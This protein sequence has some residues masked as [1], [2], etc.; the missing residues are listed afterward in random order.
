M[1]PSLIE[2]SSA[3]PPAASTALR[4]SVYSTSST[5]SVARKATRLPLIEVVIVVPL[6]LPR[7]RPGGA[8]PSVTPVPDRGP[9]KRGSAPVGQLAAEPDA[10][11]RDGERGEFDEEQADAG[12]PVGSTDADHE[13]DGEE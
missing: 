10:E 1:S 6:P 8:P 4:G 13:G 3:V 2:T 12:D 9:G 7:R 11:P 5:P